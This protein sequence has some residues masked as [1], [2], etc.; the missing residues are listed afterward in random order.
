MRSARLLFLNHAF[1]AALA[2]LGLLVLVWA[3]AGLAS[4]SLAMI[5]RRHTWL[6]YGP[7]L[8]LGSLSMISMA[9]G[10]L[11]ISLRKYSLGV[12]FIWASTPFWAVVLLIEFHQAG[13]L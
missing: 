7:P 3:L 1:H 10:L 4:G 5:S 13:Y 8:W 6:L 12:E 2:I 9:T 11:L